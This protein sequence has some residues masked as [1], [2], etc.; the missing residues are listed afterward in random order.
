M[1]AMVVPDATTQKFAD[2]TPIAPAG[3]HNHAFI[4]ARVYQF[5]VW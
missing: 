5:G 3:F 4:W 2:D 1:A